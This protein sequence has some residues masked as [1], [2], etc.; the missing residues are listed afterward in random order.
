MDRHGQQPPL[1]GL[2]HPRLHQR[3]WRIRRQGR[4]QRLHRHHPRRLALLRLLERLQQHRPERQVQ[5]LRHQGQSG[6][7]LEKRPRQTRQARL[8][9]PRQ[10]GRRTRLHHPVH[11]GQRRR[12]RLPAPRQDPQHLHQLPAEPPHHPHPRHGSAVGRRRQR[13]DLALRPRP[14]RANPRG[15]LQR[16]LLPP[17]LH[18]LRPHPPLL[19]RRLQPPKRRARQGRSGV[20]LRRRRRLHQRLLAP[21]ARRRLVVL[22]HR[23]RPR[24]P[25]HRHRP[26]APPP[27]LARPGRNPRRG[28]LQ[29]PALLAAGR[30]RLR[31]EGLC[32]LQRRRRIPLR[33][34]GLRPGRRPPPPVPAPRPVRRS[35]PLL[36]LLHVGRARAE[37]Q[38][39]RLRL[40]PALDCQPPVDP[41]RHLGQGA[42]RPHPLRLGQSGQVRH[43][44]HQRP[45]GPRLGP[46]R[47]QHQLREL[48]LR[49]LPPR[50]P[51]AQGVRRP[52][53]RRPFQRPR[54]GLRH[55]R[56]LPGSLGQGLRHHQ[57][58]RPQARP[59]SALRLRLRDRLP[60]GKQQRPLPLVLRRLHLARQA[61]AGSPVLLLARPVPH[62]AGRAL[63][64]GGRL[65][66]FRQLRRPSA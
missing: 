44:D 8:R 11:R 29:D 54:M 37:L 12:R 50:R 19:P 27:R 34:H 24:I 22:P 60:P 53:E 55:Q 6:L 62:A 7:R 47:L 13:K 61:V 59:R 25:R 57:R 46:P 48:V 30:Q 45:H 36:H 14:Q 9:R 31:D 39:R 52:H 21:R 26:D 40:E 64:R 4:H 16:Q 5:G 15:R 3:R 58:L 65:G 32:P 1:P 63:R 18:F 2:H 35:R 56:H 10:P 49:L 17:R 20:H 42:R 38:R 51:R 43:L 33:Q 28:R 41:G 23:R 66:Q